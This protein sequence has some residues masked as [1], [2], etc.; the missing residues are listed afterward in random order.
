MASLIAP[1][2]VDTND[3]NDKTVTDWEAIS[4]PAAESVLVRFWAVENIL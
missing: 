2:V 1:T 3:V 4:G